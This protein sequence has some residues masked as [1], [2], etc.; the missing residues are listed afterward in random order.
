MPM[1]QETL[2]SRK[3]IFMLNHALTLGLC[4]IFT[5]GCMAK[6]R[7]KAIEPS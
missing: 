7:P 3:T 6:E 4:A 5:D 2:F 1:A